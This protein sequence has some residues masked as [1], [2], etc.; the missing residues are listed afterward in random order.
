MV[1]NHIGVIIMKHHE[2]VKHHLK[3]AEHYNEKVKKHHE[4]ANKYADMMKHKEMPKMK[5]RAKK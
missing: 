1:F 5:K 2:K 4:E 3:K